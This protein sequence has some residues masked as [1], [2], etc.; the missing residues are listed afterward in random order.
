MPGTNRSSAQ[1]S[2]RESIIG[3]GV[4]QTVQINTVPEPTILFDANESI[5]NQGAL[6]RF[7][8]K[9]VFVVVNKFSLWS[10][11]GWIKSSILP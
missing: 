7:D 9:S 3:S 8:S 5:C 10:S 1:I 4:P 6:K 2:A 11:N